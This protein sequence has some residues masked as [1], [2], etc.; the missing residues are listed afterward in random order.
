MNYPKTASKAAHQAA[1]YETVL[2]QIET[3]L[4]GAVSR[5]HVARGV[6]WT[7]RRADLDL[8]DAALYVRWRVSAGLH[9]WEPSVRSAS[10]VYWEKLMLFRR[11]YAVPHAADCCDTIGHIGR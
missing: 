11:E 1:E 6:V 9:P 3:Y 4:A 10:D 5:R 2:A 7:A 8:M